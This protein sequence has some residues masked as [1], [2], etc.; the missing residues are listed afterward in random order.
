MKSLITFTVAMIAGTQA[1]DI[2]WWG[3]T[4]SHGEPDTS[5]GLGSLG[6]E[7]FGFDDIFGEG[8]GRDKY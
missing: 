6:L 5:F 4:P 3:E 2:Q 1:T 8:H 7:D